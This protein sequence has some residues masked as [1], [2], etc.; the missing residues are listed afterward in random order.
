LLD[1]ALALAIDIGHVERDKRLIVCAPRRR[2]NSGPKHKGANPGGN[3]S[4]HGYLYALYANNSQL[5]FVAGCPK[6]VGAK[7]PSQRAAK[8]AFSGLDPRNP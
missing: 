8:P 1:F 3:D 7:E 5:H 2:N 4:S 6:C